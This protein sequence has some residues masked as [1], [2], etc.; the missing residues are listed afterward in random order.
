MITSHTSTRL[1]RA[2]AVALTFALV[3]AFA[4]SGT[5]A[6][7]PSAGE[8]SQ[9]DQVAALKQ[10]IQENQVRL[11]RYEWIETTAVSLKGDEKSRTQ[12]QCYY[13]ADGKQQK[14]PLASN[15]PQEAPKRGLRGRIVEH[16]KEELTEYMH[17]AVALVHA[18]VP[19]DNELI[20]AAKNAG[21]VAARPLPGN[22][23]AIE[24]TDYRMQGDLVTFTFDRSLS[25]I[26]NVRIQSYIE[27]PQDAITLDVRFSALP[28]GTNHPEV[29]TLDAPAKN[30]RVTV[31]NTGYRPGR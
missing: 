6:S 21:K 13:G 27:S 29:I 26:L 11:K 23:M 18:Y 16:K 15:A 20:Q 22:A 31:E 3:A 10:S 9:Q 8:P 1:C 24:I 7:V 25:R 2:T 30:I 4:L 17:Q 12:N 19:P 28:D 14:V 5:N